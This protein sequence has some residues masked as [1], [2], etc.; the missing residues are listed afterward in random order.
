MNVA[1]KGIFFRLS[2]GMCFQMKMH[3]SKTIYTLQ[4]K[5]RSSVNDGKTMLGNN[6]KTCLKIFQNV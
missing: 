2:V 4:K 3:C 5:C 6:L 1:L